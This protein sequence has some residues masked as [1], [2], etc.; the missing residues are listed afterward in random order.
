MIDGFLLRWYFLSSMKLMPW[1]W[2][3]LKWW[4]QKCSLVSRN[5]S[6]SSELGFK[7]DQ[8]VL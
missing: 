3:V 4:I 8:P 2:S 5:K 1:G 6:T 7:G